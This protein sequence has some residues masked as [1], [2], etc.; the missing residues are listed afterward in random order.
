M[1]PRND[2]AQQIADLAAAPAAL[3]AAVDGLTDDQLDTPF[4]P[5]GWTLRQ[6]VHHT[7]DSHMHAY[8][9]MRFVLAEEH[10]TLKPYDQDRWAAFPDAAAGPVGPSLTLLAGLHARWTLL[11]EALPEDAWSRAA[12]HP[13]KGEVVL[14]D[15][16]A[17]YARHGLHHAEQIRALRAA[18]GW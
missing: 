10:P 1:D 5:G 9:R 8:A 4:R 14:S 16:L 7:A 3:A 18:R 12:H 15:M 13:E 11:L 17:Y 6:V 2:R